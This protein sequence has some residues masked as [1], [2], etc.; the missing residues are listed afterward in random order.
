MRCKEPVPYRNFS[1]GRTTSERV[2]P[3]AAR[4]EGKGFCAAENEV[5][6]S[7]HNLPFACANKIPLWRDWALALL[8]FE[9]A[10]QGSPLLP[11]GRNPY[12][13]L[14]F[15]L[16][17][18]GSVCDMHVLFRIAIIIDL[19]CAAKLGSLF[20]KLAYGKMPTAAKPRP[21]AAT[22]PES[23]TFTLF[24]DFLCRKLNAQINEYARK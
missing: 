6:S 14:T 13:E 16:A 9:L 22:C 5:S 17:G 19:K 1:T 21:T 24:Y 10:G 15:E 7:K 20:E 3:S 8:T 12:P 11:T 4:Q 18:Q 23:G 2:P